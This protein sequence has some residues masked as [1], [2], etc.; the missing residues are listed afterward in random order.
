MSSHSKKNRAAESRLLDESAIEQRAMQIARDDGRGLI[1]Q[2]DRARAREELLAPNQNVGDPEVAPE[3]GENVA[4]WDEAPAP[5]EL[6]PNGSSRKT[7]TA[8]ARP[9]SRK[10]C[11]ARTPLEKRPSRSAPAAF[12]IRKLL[13]SRD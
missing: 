1:T 11:A 4:E 5:A 3:L 6:R 13:I 8:L 10:A 7:K 12:P 9:S 2:D